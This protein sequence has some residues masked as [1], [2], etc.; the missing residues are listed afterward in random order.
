MAFHLEGTIRMEVDHEDF[1]GYGITAE[2]TGAGTDRPAEQFTSVDGTV[3][4]ETRN[5][6]VFPFGD[7][8]AQVVA[9]PA[10][11]EAAIPTNRAVRYI[12]GVD[13]QPESVFEQGLQ[14]SGSQIE[15]RGTFVVAVWEWDFNAVG[16]DGKS[17]SQRTGLQEKP[18]GD[19]PDATV[20]A[21]R[22]DSYQQA[23]LF[24]TDGVFSIPAEGQAVAYLPAG[25]AEVHGGLT[26]QGVQADMMSGDVT[27]VSANRFNVKGDL[28]VD[29]GAPVDGKIPFLATGQ[30]S[31]RFEVDGAILQW[32]G[33][34]GG[35]P[36][37]A[38]W[39]GVVAL[40][41]G[42]PTAA[43]GVRRGYLGWE[44]RQLAK[45]ETLLEVEAYG[46]ASRAASKLFGSSRLR[47]EAVVIHIEA[48]LAE[49]RAAEALP[50]LDEPRY[51][52]LAPALCDYLVARAQALLGN[53]GDARAA[54]ARAVQAAPDLALQAS[55]EPSL[56][57]LIR[58]L[59]EGYT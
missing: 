8:P 36:A 2:R 1:R 26:L 53:L 58:E 42:A 6:V 50:V 15:V 56:R 48:L 45:A 3:G 17:T 10:S 44:L 24:V 32:T 37:W 38:T 30:G 19:L 34:S 25:V 28:R 9:G 13:R 46:E 21:A 16:I 4:R 55:A 43:I 59:P 41:L 33:P 27:H 18:L 12:E 11:V 29:L 31:P 23:F 22:D 5:L 57:P 40:A 51:W 35:W 47:S 20:V 49:G 54:L 52:I 14:V 7:E 39:A